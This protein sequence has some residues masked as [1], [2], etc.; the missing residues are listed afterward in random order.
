MNEKMK[1][2]KS[3]VLTYLSCPYRYYLEYIEKKPVAEPEE[4]KI[5]RHMHEIID[6]YF[7]RCDVEKMS[8][9]EYKDYIQSVIMD[10]LKENP[11]VSIA[12]KSMI[13]NF[14]EFEAL[15][16]STLGDLSYYLPVLSEKYAEIELKDFYIC[17]VVDRVFKEKNG[18]SIVE[19]KTGFP[20][21]FRTSIEGI[22]LE[23]HIYYSIVVGSNI[24]G[25]DSYS[26][27]SLCV[28][29]PR[30]NYVANIKLPEKRDLEAMMRK[31]YKVVRGINNKKFDKNPGLKCRTCKFVSVCMP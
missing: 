4:V 28:Y 30:E 24:L 18:Y 15:R 26:V 1:L 25:D 29:Y 19:T 11:P 2:D 16:A 17:G 27:N 10:V 8:R 20:P 6:S 14:I 7:K 31:L 22:K 5:G 21:K 9:S 12:E 23:M 13:E 3:Q